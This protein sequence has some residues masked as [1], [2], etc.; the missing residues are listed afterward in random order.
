M[1]NALKRLFMDTDKNPKDISD[2]VNDKNNLQIAT[3]AIFLEIAYSDDDFSNIEKEQ[4]FNIIRKQFSLSDAEIEELLKHTEEVRKKSVSLYEFTE[5]INN[6]LSAEDKYKIV[7]NL[8]RI[9]LADNVINSYEEYFIRK[10]SGNLNVSHNNLIAAKF[11][12]KKEM[13]SFNS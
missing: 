4:I 9:I 1:L 5:V 8:W 7:E 3:C 11:A 10:I 12:V 13:E 2:V 6:N